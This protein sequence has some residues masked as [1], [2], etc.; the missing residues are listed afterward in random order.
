[1]VLPILVSCVSHVKRISSDFSFYANV[2]GAHGRLYQY[3]I[4]QKDGKTECTYVRMHKRKHKCGEKRNKGWGGSAGVEKKVKRREKRERDAYT[5]A[6]PRYHELRCSLRMYYTYA[7]AACTCKHVH[8]S[9]WPQSAGASRGMQSK[10]QQRDRARPTCKIRS[11]VYVILY[12]SIFRDA[13]KFT[14]DKGERER[15]SVCRQFIIFARKNPYGAY[16]RCIQERRCRYVKHL[17]DVL[18][19]LY[20]PSLLTSR[21]KFLNFLFLKKGAFFGR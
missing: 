7:D 16:E 15:I 21:N 2:A 13:P 8:T 6:T 18:L 12:L 14:E 3:E 10:T 17:A 1:M 19:F 4:T 5:S 20:D 9:S 11:R